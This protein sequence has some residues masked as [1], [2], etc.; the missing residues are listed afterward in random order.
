MPEERQAEEVQERADDHVKGLEPVRLTGGSLTFNQH[1]R[2]QPPCVVTTKF[3]SEAPESPG[4]G[5]LPQQTQEPSG[6]LLRCWRSPVRGPAAGQTRC[7][8]GS[9]AKH[10]RTRAS[11]TVSYE[12]WPHLA[13]RSHTVTLECHGGLRV[14]FP[15]LQRQHD[16][17]ET[18]GG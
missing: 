16:F 2:N 3:K 8:V 14:A 1:R 4:H 9:F 7:Y 12:R 15:F 6:I 5:C 17:T 10:P 13:I 18:P 11:C